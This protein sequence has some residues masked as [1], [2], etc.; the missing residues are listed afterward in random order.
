[1][2]KIIVVVALVALIAFGLGILVGRLSTEQQPVQ[3]VPVQPSAVAPLFTYEQYALLSVGGRDTYQHACEVFGRP[4]EEISNTH[5]SNRIGDSIINVYRWSNA[6]G[7]NAT[8]TFD[9][10]VLSSK[11]QIGLPHAKE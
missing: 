10:G 6:D 1:M 4:G 11:Q 5:I 7:S 2:A 8:L 9:L 3:S